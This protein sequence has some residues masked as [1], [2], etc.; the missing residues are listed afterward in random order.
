MPLIKLL[1]LSADEILKLIEPYGFNHSHAIAITNNLYKKGHTEVSQFGKIPSKLKE[2]LKNISVTGRFSP[3]TSEVSSDRSVKYLF[4]TDEGLGFETVY[5]PDSKRNTV[6]V[7]TQSG[8]RMGC[9]FC[10][11]GKYGFRGNLSTGEIVNQVISIPHAKDVT[12][13][14]F[15]GMGEPMDNL[16]N[17]LKACE[18]LT[19]E[20]GCS[21]GSANVTVSS[22]GLIEGVNEFLR[23]SDCNLTLS[24]YSPFSE[25]RRK[26]IPSELKNPAQKVLTVMANYPI[27]KKRRLCVA[28]IMIKD[29]NDSDSHLEGLKSLLNQTGIRV[30]LLPYHA[31]N[32]DQNISSTAERMQYFKHSLILSGISASI[33]KSR[34][35][36]I[37]AACG[38]LAANRL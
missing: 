21:L 34:G 36:D 29:L 33:R 6:C 28:Y 14:V 24:L 5:I 16:A 25:E 37:S 13:V 12:N 22:V 19:S 9:A 11:T 35:K 31:L 38:L 23:K 30:N 4:R 20:W 2:V 26:V 15:M 18:I 1:G 17:V 8:C 3:V 27:R 7:S 10:A 32:D